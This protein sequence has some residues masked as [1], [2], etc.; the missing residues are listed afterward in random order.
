M[1]TKNE[2]NCAIIIFINAKSVVFFTPLLNK[3]TNIF[4]LVGRDTLRLCRGHSSALDLAARSGD[5]CFRVDVC[6]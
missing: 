1:P 4:I 5:D 6:H 2:F 3:C